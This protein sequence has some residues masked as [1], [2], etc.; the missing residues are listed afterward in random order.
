[1]NG[2][3][4]VFWGPTLMDR[5]WFAMSIPM[6]WGISKALEKFMPVFSIVLFYKFF[7]IDS[8]KVNLS[9]VFLI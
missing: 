7:L 3:E 5:F 4:E 9:L 6:D 8:E 2:Q 1:M